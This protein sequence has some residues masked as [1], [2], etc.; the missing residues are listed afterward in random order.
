MIVGDTQN[1]QRYPPPRPSELPGIFGEAYNLG[2]D[3]YAEL[4][5]G[6]TYP[7]SSNRVSEV[8]PPAPN[9]GRS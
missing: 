9:S 4:F 3:R 2:T 5:T 6:F 7:P 8:V 1:F